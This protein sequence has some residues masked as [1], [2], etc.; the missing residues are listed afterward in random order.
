MAVACLYLPAVGNAAADFGFPAVGG[1]TVGGA[2]VSVAV[3]V[4]ACGGGKVVFAAAVH[5]GGGVQTALP[6]ACFDAAFKMATG[7]GFEVA[8]VAVFLGLGYKQTA[9]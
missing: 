5:D 1:G 3:G 8:A 7:N 6:P 2:V 4:T 9:V